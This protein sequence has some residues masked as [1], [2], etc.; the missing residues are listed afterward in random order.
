MCKI[1]LDQYNSDSKKPLIL[2]CGHTFCQ[3][4]ISKSY[5]LSQIRCPMDKK[6]FIYPKLED[7]GR[8]WD[9]QDCLQLHA[10]KQKKKEFHSNAYGLCSLHQRKV[11]FCCE[12]EAQVQLLCSECIGNYLGLKHSVIPLRDI[13]KLTTKVIEQK[14]R[15]CENLI[16]S[17]KSNETERANNLKDEYKSMKRQIEN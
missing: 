7:I 1:C 13:V 8:N 15:N 2:N 14:V 16:K 5:S 11:K 10:E 17:I 3:D 9:I 12:S 4:C 6:T